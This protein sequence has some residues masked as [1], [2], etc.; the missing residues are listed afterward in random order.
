[1]ICW[2]DY[3]SA[4]A[5]YEALLEVCPEVEEY[6][7]YLAQALYKGGCYHE[8][9]RAAACVESPRYAR[10]MLLLQ[11]CGS[12]MSLKGTIRLYL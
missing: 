2:Q 10:R 3:S 7:V 8:A 5:T 6:R 11:V 12:Q 1:L 4:A 9:M